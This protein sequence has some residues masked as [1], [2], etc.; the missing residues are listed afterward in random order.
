MTAVLSEVATNGAV[1]QH[2]PGTIGFSVGEIVRYIGFVV[3]LQRC[4]RPE[5][6]TSSYGQ[7]VSI[8]ENMNT[9]IRG[10]AA[11]SEW[12][13]I[14]SDDHLWQEDALRCLLDREVDVVVPLIIKRS[15]PFIPVINAEIRE[16]RSYRPFPYG[17]IP[18]S[19]LLEVEAAGSG[20]MLIR[21]H[22]FQAIID[23]Q[24]H[25]RVFEVEAGDKLAEDYVLC[26]KIREAG[27]KIYC[28]V[29]VTMGHQGV[30]AVWP[31]V[32]DDKWV[33]RF[34]M[35]TNQQGGISSFY[36]GTDQQQEVV[37]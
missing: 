28:D 11:E 20:G 4:W 1:K 15:P 17:E 10:M 2:P 23:K 19:G 7:S 14:Q 27:F 8:P 36:H 33:L 25:D 29:E 9:I 32:M 35:G 37:K 34:D 30:F 5:G 3:S 16:D 13:W 21:R 12:L 24:G 26:R 22:V 18:T 6:T 31:Q